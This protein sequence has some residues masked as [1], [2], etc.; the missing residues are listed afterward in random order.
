TLLRDAR[1]EP[2]E[3]NVGQFIMAQRAGLRLEAIGLAIGYH[4]EKGEADQ[5]PVILVE[6]LHIAGR[7]RAGS[8]GRGARRE[9][10]RF[11]SVEAHEIG[12]LMLAVRKN[13][14]WCQPSVGDRLSR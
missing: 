14:G 9:A 4:R 11:D 12:P 2:V 7:D 3:Q 1:F 8:N 10:T 13:S 6:A 5:R